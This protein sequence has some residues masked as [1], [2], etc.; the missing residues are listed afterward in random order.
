[1][2]Q[3]CKLLHSEEE[4]ELV[5]LEKFVKKLEEKTGEFYFKITDE[6]IQE[7]LEKEGKINA[8]MED[9]EEEIRKGASEKFEEEHA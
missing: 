6:T 4:K 2:V 5:K 8:E 3:K 1:M 7:E 9:K